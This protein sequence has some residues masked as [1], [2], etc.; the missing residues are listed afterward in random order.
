ML[1]L[2]LFFCSSL[3]NTKPDVLVKNVSLTLNCSLTKLYFFA[4]KSSHKQTMYGMN[5]VDL[6]ISALWAVNAPLSHLCSHSHHLPSEYSGTF[7]LSVI[8][9]VSTI[10][11]ETYICLSIVLRLH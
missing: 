11:I 2:F 5:T 4:N 6:E 7:F 9:G 8:L 3:C 1:N 10:F